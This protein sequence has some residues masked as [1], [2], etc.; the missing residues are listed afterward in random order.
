MRPMNTLL[1]VVAGMC[2]AVRCLP[3]AG[4]DNPVAVRV[5]AY[6]VEFGK[7]ANPTQVGEMFKPYNLD[8]IGFNEVRMAIGP[9]KWAKCLAWTTATWARSLRQITRTNT[10]RFSVGRHLR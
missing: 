6:N 8:I 1:L 10:N 5:A 4:P 9:L 7:N 2:A 3:A